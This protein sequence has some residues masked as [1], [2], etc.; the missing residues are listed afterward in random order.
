MN[1]Y[2]DHQLLI[3]LCLLFLNTSISAQTLTVTSTAETGPG[4]L[5]EAMEMANDNNGV[6]TIIFNL[7]GNGPFYLTTGNPFW[8]GGTVLDA[9]TQPDFYLGKIVIGTDEDNLENFY[10]LGDDTEIYGIKAGEITLDGADGSKIG[11]PGKE[12]VLSMIYMENS[13]NVI[14]QSNRI[15]TNTEGTESAGTD[16]YGIEIQDCKDVLIGGDLPEEGNLISGN[17][18][19]GMYVIDMNNGV[20]KNNKIGT[21]IT[22]NYA[23]PNEGKGIAAIVHHA[24]TIGDGSSTGNLVSGNMDDGISTGS[25][26][27]S[28]CLIAGNK[29]GT[30]ITGLQPIPNQGNGMTIQAQTPWIFQENIVG[31]NEGF[32][33]EVGDN[34]INKKHFIQNTFSCNQDGGYFIELPPLASISL[35]SNSLISGTS[36]SVENVVEIFWSDTITCLDSPCQGQ[37]FIG[38]VT[39]NS[40]GNWELA[41]E[42]ETG[43]Y[44]VNLTPDDERTV[45][46]SECLLLE[47]ES[48]STTFEMKKEGYVLHQNQP[49]PFREETYIELEVPRNEEGLLKIF[50]STG[51]LLMERKQAFVRGEN[52]IMVS[53]NDCP[54]NG[55]YFYQIKIGDVTLV[56]RMVKI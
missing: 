41:G 47:V 44:M 17:G 50:N 30:D 20:I 8:N 33:I 46:I 24:I 12:N 45:M 13:D 31:F 34:I 53:G 35:L 1:K 48:P 16:S 2:H 26:T 4:T 18:D 27:N 54:I 22:G 40:A 5:D 38:S 56:G 37:Q 19:H 15:G 29:V 32:G 9:T 7:A 28:D 51:R 3:F 23:I 10:A 25:V 43:Y 14:V 36:N 42:F 21:D 55:I 6:D 52:M 39:T 49:N 11:A